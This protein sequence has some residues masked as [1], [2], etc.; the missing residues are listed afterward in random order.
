MMRLALVTALAFV[1][2]ASIVGIAMGGG[3]GETQIHVLKLSVDS[4][5]TGEKDLPL[6][7]VIPPGGGDKPLV[8]FLHGRGQTPGSLLDA[9]FFSAYE[10]MGTRAPVV[11][12]PYGDDHSYWHNR[13]DGKWRTYLL[14]EVLPLVESETSIDTSRLAIAGIS[15]GGFGA[16]DIAEARPHKFCA[17]AGHS[18]ALWRSS[19]ETAPGAFDDAADFHRNDVIAR[20]SRL[21]GMRVWLDAGDADPFLAGDDAFV[22]ALSDVGGTATVHHPPGDHSTTYWDA[23]WA[24]YL[25]YYA[26][27]LRHCG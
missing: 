20:V 4:K 13:A 14:K 25:A 6:D 8:V 19:G 21:V 22:K 24:T 5:A 1:L 18:P 12:M 9:A 10:A 2:V 7:V 16:L 26:R 15:M 11:A 23:H 17:V 27:A 3:N